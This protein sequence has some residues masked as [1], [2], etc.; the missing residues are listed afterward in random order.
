MNTFSYLFWGGVFCLI[1][2]FLIDL[3]LPEK[4]HWQVSPHLN[5]HMWKQRTHL[6]RITYVKVLATSP[7]WLKG[8]LHE[9][10]LHIFVY[11]NVNNLLTND[12]CVIIYSKWNEVC[13]K[14]R[15][16]KWKLLLTRVLSMYINNHVSLLQWKW[17][18]EWYV[19][20]D[21]DGKHSITQLPKRCASPKVCHTTI[22]NVSRPTNAKHNYFSLLINILSNMF[23]KSFIPSRFYTVPEV[24]PLS[25][26]MV[27]RTPWE[28]EG[29]W[30]A[31]FLTSETNWNICSRSPL[32]SSL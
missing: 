17:L 19:K 21:Q 23:F 27:M 29:P 28:G 2:L 22:P 5:T 14:D 7:T 13:P 9:E 25:L 8:N 30:L 26:Q 20:A 10:M 18:H 16:C 11:I 31:V 24:S 12:N 6:L 3:E 4:N 1:I 15:L 32:V